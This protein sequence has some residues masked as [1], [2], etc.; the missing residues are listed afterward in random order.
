[1]FVAKK[2]ILLLV[3]FTFSVAP[4]W[5]QHQLVKP[6]ADS[7]LSRLR[8]GGQSYMV[9]NMRIGQETLGAGIRSRIGM[10]LVTFK[11]RVKYKAYAVGSKHLSPVLL[12]RL[13]ARNLVKEPFPAYYL[14]F[15][16]SWQNVPEVSLGRLE[17]ILEAA[18]GEEALF[19][20]AFVPTYRDVLNIVAQQQL[21][22]TAR[23]A[24]KQAYEQG[25][26]K[27][28]GFFVIT[29]HET[30]EHGYDVLLLDVANKHFISVGQSIGQAWMQAPTKKQDN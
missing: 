11:D 4:V 16:K 6:L 25:L 8:A 22:F 10:T 27:Q 7:F 13:V 19:E 23:G 20:G 18:Y 12:E 17:V 2:S 28:S 24:L 14:N 1:M 21:Q 15:E 9:P 5:A 30:P 26:Q 3:F 29:V